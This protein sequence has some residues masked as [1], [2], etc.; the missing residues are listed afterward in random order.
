M[1]LALVLGWTF[2]TNL[3]VHKDIYTLHP[4]IQITVQKINHFISEEKIIQLTKTIPQNLET[5]KI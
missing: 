2:T 1:I 3:L 5:S 4:V